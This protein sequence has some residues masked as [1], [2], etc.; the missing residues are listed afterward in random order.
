ME[1]MTVHQSIAP[2]TWVDTYGDYL[3]GFICLKELP[4]RAARALTLRELEG[5]STQTICKV[6]NVTP[7][8]CWVILHRARFQSRQCDDVPV[9]PELPQT[10]ADHQP[11]HAVNLSRFSDGF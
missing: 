10:A 8:N 1:T 2:D 5:E 9:L 6:L 11:D 3:C 4:E 7:T